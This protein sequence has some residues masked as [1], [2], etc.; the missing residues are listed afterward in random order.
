[1]EDPGAGSRAHVVGATEADGRP[2]LVLRTSDGVRL[3]RLAGPFAMRVAGPRMC[4]GRWADGRHVP[5]PDAATVGPEATCL[6][7]S[8]LE[9]PECV[10]EPLCQ[11]DEAACLCARTFRDVPHAVY[12]AFYG[13]LAKVGLTQER[14]LGRRL[15]EQGAD[16]YFVVAR[17]LD[18]G[19]ARRL[20]RAVSFLEGIP[21][22]RSHREVL[23]L[24][25]RPVEWDLVERRAA[26]LA[27]AL[28]ARYPVDP[29]L[30]R[31][32][33]H[34]VAQPLPGPPRRIRL[35]GAHEGAWLGAKGGHL[36]YA[37][38]GKPGRLDVGAA[39]VAALHRGDLVGHF[40]TMRAGDAPA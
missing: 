25:A 21:E 34:P 30:H 37:E 5:C 17:G 2:A 35:H 24:L 31:V 26:S 15:R 3:E 12:C 8:G 9:H 4:T 33:D 18:R 38:S 23:P 20:E 36:F 19:G 6:P 27:Q 13:P 39:P 11:G 32:A 1:M 28:A 14:R 22:H 16:L 10:F 40:V 7:C 29:T